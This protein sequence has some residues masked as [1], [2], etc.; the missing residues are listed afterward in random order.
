MK[1]IERVQ[2]TYPRKNTDKRWI[3]NNGNACKCVYLKQVQANICECDGYFG[4]QLKK[5][6]R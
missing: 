2:Q 4:S 5:R 1:N 3:E 6:Q